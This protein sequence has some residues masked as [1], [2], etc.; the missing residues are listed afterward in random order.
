MIG[1]MIGYFL[2]ANVQLEELGQIELL[3]QAGACG[4]PIKPVARSSPGSRWG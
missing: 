1:Q 3:P 4:A 2:T